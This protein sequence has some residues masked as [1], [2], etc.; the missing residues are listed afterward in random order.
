ME[1]ISEPNPQNPIL[2]VDDDESIL[3]SID[4]MLRMAGWDNIITCRDSRRVMEILSG[5]P[6]EIALL[7]L[8]MPDIGGEDLLPGIREADI[9]VI[10][11]T[12]AVDVGTAVRCIKAGAFDY[13]VKPVEEDH[14]VAAVT[15]ALSF[16]ELKK[17]NLAL[18]RHVV[19]DIS[20][21]LRHPE[22]FGDI[23]TGN[24]KMLLIFEYVET[25]AKTSQPVLVTGETG[26][27]KELVAR[28][29]HSLSGLSGKFVAVNAAGLDD[30]MFSDTLFGHVRGAFTGADQARS[31]LI[32]QAKGGTLFLDEI[33]DLSPAS[34]VKLLRLLQ[35]GD[36]LPIG[37]DH[38][39][40]AEVRIVA[41]TNQDL[42]A[43]QKDGR[44]RKD[45]NYRL[46]TH[47]IHIP[48][49]RERMADIPILTDHFLEQAANELAKKKPAPPAELFK[50]LQTYSFPGNI[51]ELQSMIF[52]AVSRHDSGTLSLSVFKSHIVG[53][54]TGESSDATKKTAE[55]PLTFGKKLPTI[56]QATQLLVDEAMRRTGGNQTMAAKM[57]GI[58]Q[59]ALSKRLKK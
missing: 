44:F 3:L 54:Q 15:R 5:Q 57:M 53:E 55:S 9:P 6:I 19:S 59:Q 11:V 7:D 51:R 43:L 32:E 30:N 31:G 26:V 24:R 20:T 48:P 38:P 10:I 58:S 4:T 28:S 8:T 36:Y 22:A 16:Q 17:E 1:K 14:L 29:L 21:H 52:D 13:I 12:G 45:L 40:P 39:K 18:R 47:R 41:A 23:I 50:L 34:Q 42:S 33:G 49:L 27:G 46:T 56:K 37:A 35:E 2:I 25:I